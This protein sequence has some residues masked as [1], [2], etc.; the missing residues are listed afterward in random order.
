MLIKNR[1]AGVGFLI[2]VRASTS[3]SLAIGAASAAS[4][5]LVQTL[6]LIN[7]NFTLTQAKAREATYPCARG[8]RRRSRQSGLQMID[9]SVNR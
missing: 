2:R 6:A 1:G 5:N 8:Y 3:D 4:A 9:S 7:E